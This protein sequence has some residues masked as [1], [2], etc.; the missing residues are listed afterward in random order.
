M[1]WDG[2]RAPKK[3]ET[4]IQPLFLPSRVL[5]KSVYLVSRVGKQEDIEHGKCA[6]HSAG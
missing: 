6:R 4:T 5:Q 3:F 2:K 1:E